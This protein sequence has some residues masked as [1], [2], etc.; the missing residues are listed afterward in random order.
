MVIDQIEHLCQQ[1][2]LGGI[3][4]GW[5]ALSEQAVKDKH[6]YAGFLSHHLQTTRSS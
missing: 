6:S 1:L 4:Q 2:K 3:A 5:S